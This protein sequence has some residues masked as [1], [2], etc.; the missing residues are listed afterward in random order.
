MEQKANRHIQKFN[1]LV[2]V[3]GPDGIEQLDEVIER[4]E[5]SLETLREEARSQL[6][7]VENLAVEDFFSEA[8]LAEIEDRDNVDSPASVAR[9]QREE[10]ADRLERIESALTDAIERRVGDGDGG[11]TGEID[12]QPAEDLIDELD[13]PL[14]GVDDEFAEFDD[15]F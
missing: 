7:A 12:A 5:T 8:E 11:D 9:K 15:D 10:L 2:T 13:E 14:E 4:D 6:D 1:Q 3:Y